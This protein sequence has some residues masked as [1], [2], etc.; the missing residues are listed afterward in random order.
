MKDSRQDYSINLMI[1][2]VFFDPIRHDFIACSAFSRIGVL[3]YRESL[4]AK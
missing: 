4:V 1:F 3:E 2:C